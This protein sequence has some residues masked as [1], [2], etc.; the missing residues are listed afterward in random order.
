MLTN[1]NGDYCIHVTVGSKGG[2]ER[3]ARIIGTE[4]EKRRI[5]EM[6]NGAGEDRVFR[7]LPDRFSYHVLRSIYACRYIDLVTPDVSKIPGKY[8]Y[9][10]KGEISGFCVD[11]RT[12]KEVSQ[13]LGHNRI[14]VIRNYFRGCLFRNTLGKSGM[15]ITEEVYA[16]LQEGKKFA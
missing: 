12:M 13:S 7:D 14:G 4:S 5:I 1:R 10:F 3:Y 6:M 11:R 15:Q 16:L 9:C 2:R 8:R